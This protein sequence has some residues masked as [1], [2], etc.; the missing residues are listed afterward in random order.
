MG[1]HKF[2]SVALEWQN[3]S[4]LRFESIVLNAATGIQL[5]ETA[6]NLTD[7]KTNHEFELKNQGFL[8]PDLRISNFIILR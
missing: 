6:Y 7:M 3:V 8:N 1:H 2:C 4:R 5:G